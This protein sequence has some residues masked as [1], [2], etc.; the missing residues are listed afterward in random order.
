MIKIEFRFNLSSFGSTLDLSLCKCSR[1]RFN[2]FLSARTALRIFKIDLRWQKVFQLF[3]NINSYI[4]ALDLSLSVAKELGCAWTIV[5]ALENIW[6]KIIN[7]K[8]VRRANVLNDTHR[9]VCVC[10]GACVLDDRKLRQILCKSKRTRNGKQRAI[11][12]QAM[13]GKLDFA[14]TKANSSI[15]WQWKRIRDIE[16]DA[17]T[18]FELKFLIII[19]NSC[20][21]VLSGT[22]NLF[23]LPVQRASER[24]AL[25]AREQYGRQL[26]F[27]GKLC[28][29]CVRARRQVRAKSAWNGK[30]G[31]EQCALALSLPSLFVLRSCC[32]LSRSPS[33]WL[34]LSGVA[35]ARC[36]VFCSPRVMA[37]ESIC[38]TRFGSM[39]DDDDGSLSHFSFLASRFSLR[40]RQPKPSHG[41]LMEILCNGCGAAHAVFADGKS[42]PC[43]RCSRFLLSLSYS[44]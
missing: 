40:I 33:L 27:G 38:E 21:E 7:R 25:P 20:S 31:Q 11:N 14:K 18:E 29:C 15:I 12:M 8:R 22:G 41:S 35:G 10:V 36:H 37:A 16:S 17:K 30:T 2:K 5:A 19:R 26:K 3:Y 23:C 34:S 39:V 1:W 13:Y 32:S 24:A 4:S 43:L 6:Q 9:R 44:R 42:W 28:S